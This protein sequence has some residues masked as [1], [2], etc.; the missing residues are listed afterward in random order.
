M[1]VKIKVTRSR[2]D[3]P[4]A[5][6]ERLLFALKWLTITA[7]FIGLVIM[8]S[9]FYLSEFQTNTTSSSGTYSCPPCP[10]SISP[11]NNPS[12]NV[13]YVTSWILPLA[14]L[15]ILSLI[16]F[17]MHVEKLPREIIRPFIKFL[18]SLDFEINYF[19]GRFISCKPQ[20]ESLI[21][22]VDKI[23]FQFLGN[24]FTRVRI[25]II[26]VYLKAENLNDIGIKSIAADQGFGIVYDDSDM[27]KGK[28]S[29]YLVTSIDVRRVHAKSLNLRLLLNALQ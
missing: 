16:L 4:L 5:K 28:I 13:N 18:E 8:T 15:V 14:I 9:E 2:E 25:C 10:P 1:N 11:A 22:K 27:I 23:T 7:F 17:M 21:T 19:Y 24:I 6:K 26:R 3:N 12:T 29:S 20:Q